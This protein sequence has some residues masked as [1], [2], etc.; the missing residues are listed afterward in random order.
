MPCI[1]PTW[2]ATIRKVSQRNADDR[3]PTVDETRVH[4]RPAGRC[5]PALLERLRGTPARSKHLIAGISEEMLG[6]RPNGKW[7][8]KDP[9]GHLVDLQPLDEQR[10]RVFLG[11]APMLS[12]ADISNRATGDANHRETPVAEILRQLRAGREELVR[13]LDAL[14]RGRR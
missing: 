5:F 3:D 11:C 6:T 7:S 4:L 12:A 13:I 1:S 8:V 10:L 14:K 9:L 2:H